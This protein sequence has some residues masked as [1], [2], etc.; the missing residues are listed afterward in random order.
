MHIDSSVES[1]HSMTE[2]LKS[3]EFAP[4][5]RLS[6]INLKLHILTNIVGSASKDDHEGA[7]EES[8]VLVSS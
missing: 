6:L 3:R 1:P 7:D 4:F 2:A 5:R 8:G